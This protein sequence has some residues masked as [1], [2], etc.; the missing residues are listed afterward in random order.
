MKRLLL[1][2]L[3]LTNITIGLF[4]QTD[5]FYSENG[6]EEH[7]KIRKVQIFSPSAIWGSSITLSR[8]IVSGPPSPR[9][10]TLS[11]T[12]YTSNYQYPSGET[13]HQ[14]YGSTLT[15]TNGGYANLTLTYTDRA[16]NP[17]YIAVSSYAVVG[18]SCGNLSVNSLGN[19]MS[20]N[21]GQNACVHT[22]YLD[23]V[24]YDWCG[25]SGQAFRIPYKIVNSSYPYAYSNA[26]SDV[27]QSSSNVKSTNAGG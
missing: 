9:T 27:L 10:G 21:A 3:L 16:G 5:F 26:V 23:I 2:T 25:S 12:G 4:A 14:S 6:K 22:G 20:I 24:V 1:L 15:L 13:T 7:F 8:D 11:W 17:S 19:T 18:S